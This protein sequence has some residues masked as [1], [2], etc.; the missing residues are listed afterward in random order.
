MYEGN[1]TALNATDNALAQA[2]ARMVR[3]HDAMLSK[4]DVGRSWYDAD[5]LREMNEAPIEALR[6][7]REIGYEPLPRRTFPAPSRYE[8]A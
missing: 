5:T 1:K 3:M 2:L 7:L 4:T 8:G 6:A